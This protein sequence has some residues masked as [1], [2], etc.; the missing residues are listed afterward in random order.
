[1][2]EDEL[3]DREGPIQEDIALQRKRWR[4]ERAGFIGL[5][6]IVALALA[7]MFSTGPLSDTVATSA[8]GR[9]A[10]HY[11]RF[12][13]NGAQDDLVIEAHGQPGEMMRVALSSHWLKGMSIEGLNPQPAPLTSQGRDLL[14]PMLAD[15]DGLATLYLTVRCDG[16]GLYRGAFVLQGAQSVATAKFIYP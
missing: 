10:V 6:V 16:V 14:I 5:L 11:Q 13:R 7:G 2:A 1:M 9:L 15:A 3:R 12:S 4:F 8:D